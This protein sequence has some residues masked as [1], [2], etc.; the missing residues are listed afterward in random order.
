MFGLSQDFIRRRTV[1]LQEDNCDGLLVNL[2]CHDNRSQPGY[3][4]SYLRDI[5]RRF[6]LLR[7][8][9]KAEYYVGKDYDFQCH[10]P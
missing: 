8:T 7:I 10:D 6:D 5:G 4:E 9:S 2:R 3:S 1:I